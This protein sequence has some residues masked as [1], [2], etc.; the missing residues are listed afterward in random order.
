M[1]IRKK[2]LVVT[3]VLFLSVMAVNQFSL[4]MAADD[5]QEVQVKYSKSLF[6]RVLVSKEDRFAI[7]FGSGSGTFTAIGMLPNGTPVFLGYYYGDGSFHVSMKAALVYA[8]IWER[9]LS[10]LG[11]DPESVNPGMLFLGV[12]KR[13]NGFYS[14]AFSVPIRVDKILDGYAVK[15][16][17]SAPMIKLSQ[18]KPIKENLTEK[19]ADKSRNGGVESV[20]DDYP[21]SLGDRDAQSLLMKLAPDRIDNKCLSSGVCLYWAPDYRI[22]SCGINSSIPLVIAHIWGNRDDRDAGHIE[23][24]MATKSSS[25]ISISFSALGVENDGGSITQIS[26]GPVFTLKEDGEWME[27]DTHFYGKDLP[28]GESYVMSGIVGHYVVMRYRL[29]AVGY[30]DGKEFT[31]PYNSRAF[32]TIV[33]PVLEGTPEGVKIKTWDG[34]FSADDGSKLVEKVKGIVN[35]FDGYRNYTFTKSVDVDTW[36][37]KSESHYTPLFSMGI[38]VGNPGVI[39]VAGFSIGMSS[40][41]DSFL[42][43]DVSYT[44]WNEDQRFEVTTYKLKDVFLYLKDKK[45]Y[46]IPV[47][48]VDI[49]EVPEYPPTPLLPP[50]RIIYPL[51]ETAWEG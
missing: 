3:L 37:L 29:Y 32:F 42:K 49:Y 21:P 22:L 7:Y 36:Q 41:D 10:H 24:F 33:V 13:D 46:V 25:G 15:V 34:I 45:S 31:V 51:T 23:T 2:I 50:H 30:P 5:F 6:S 20:W 40:E 16:H 26:A 48:Y 38:S 27:R 19:T 14:T 18:L 28:G 39:P 35:T 44:S 1:N 47:M 11:L 9:Y 17:V 4:K 8:R 12:V 43:M